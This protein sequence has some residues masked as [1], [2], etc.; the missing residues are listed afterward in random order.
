MELIVTSILAFASTNIDDI[1][2]LLLFFGNKAYKHPQVILGQYIGIIALIVISFIG[3]L[4]GLL[5]DPRY[6]GLLGLLP[7][8]FGIRGMVRLFR[9][10]QKNDLDQAT[11]RSKPSNQALAVA[12]ITFANGGDNIGIYIPLFATLSVQHRVIMIFIFLLMVAVWCI[13]ARYLSRHRAVAYTIEKYG[14]LITPVILILLGTYILYESGW[15]H[16]LR[17]SSI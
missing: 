16:F 12:A 2:I 3:S 8:Y 10:Q 14:H 1:F 17:S 13:A 15:L 11:I 6:I 5:V 4:V 9:R 7:V